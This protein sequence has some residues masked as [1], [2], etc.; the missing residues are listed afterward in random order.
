MDERLK[1]SISALL[2]DEANE[3]E[4][5]RILN[6]SGD[7][8]LKSLWGRYN[9]VSDVLSSGRHE[10]DHFSPLDI[11]ISSRISQAIDDEGELE[12]TDHDSSVEPK[13]PQAN[14]MRWMGVAAVLVL[15]VSLAFNPFSQD[16]DIEDEQLIAS[17][18]F[19]RGKPLD[20]GL[21]VLDGQA[22]A[23]E[24]ARK[25]N[26]YL[27]RHAGNSVTGGRSG[28]MPLVR[29]ASLSMTAY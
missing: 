8:E 1:E 26:E 3:L 17:V 16:T 12:L 4:I 13:T 22:L 25:L 2:D 28:L 6:K 15:T 23:P 9:K 20:A 21:S 10:Y 27:L 14:F 24:H 29:V 5:R 18:G 7:D 11:D 19:E